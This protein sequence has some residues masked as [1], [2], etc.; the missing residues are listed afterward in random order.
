MN[1]ILDFIPV[2]FRPALNALFAFLFTVSAFFSPVQPAP[3]RHVLNESDFL[4]TR[5]TRIVNAANNEIYLRGTN[6]GGWLVFEQWMCAIENAPDQQ[7]IISTLTERFGEETCDELLDVYRDNF[8]Q[9]QDFD[10]C[11]ELGLN[12]IRL[13]FNVYS[14]ASADG[15]LKD[16]IFSRLDWFV[17]N[18]GKRGIYVILDMHGAFGSQN[19]NDHTGIINDGR[20]L[21]YNAENRAKTIALW[22]RIAEHYKDN[23]AVAGYD[24]LNE[25]TADTGSTGEMQWDF[26]DELYDAVRAVDPNHIII[27][28]ACWTFLDLPHPLRYGWKNVMYEY[29]YYAWDH[30]KEPEFIKLHTAMQIIATG[31]MLHNVPVLVGEFTFFDQAD[32]WHYGLDSFNK[33]KWNWTTW[34][35]KILGTSSWGLYNY[36]PEDE[37]YFPG[38]A[39]IL[40]DSEATIREKWSKIGTDYCVPGTMQGIIRQYF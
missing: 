22:T 11:A 26:Y 35:Y 7:T 37:G 27:M 40:N 32:A 38:R 18:C 39:D 30:D 36:F 4:H 20:Q 2:F 16:D 34:T 5:G 33:V 12:V 1:A 17:D 25:P 24:L 31:A 19:G 15:V 14:F 13:P 23:P 21:Y 8:W 3:A 10:N 6:A 28:E 29:H 9:E